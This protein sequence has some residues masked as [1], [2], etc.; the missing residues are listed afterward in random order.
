M[1]I[2]KKNLVVCCLAP[3]LVLGACAQ[4]PK[5]KNTIDLPDG[6]LKKIEMS[7]AEWKQKLNEFEFYV[8]RDKGT[9]RAFTGEFWDNKKSGTYTCGGCALPLF[10][11]TTKFKSGTGWPSFWE[12][13]NE[14]YVAE[15]TDRAFGMVR[16]EVLC[17]RCDGH[18][19]HVFPDGPKPTGLRYC[20]NSISLDFI[21]EAKT[22]E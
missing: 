21:P 3:L 1:V 22:T 5:D 16:T 19:G 4:I 12:P 13:I 7:E 8:L 9:E 6:E 15:E 17:A 18:L 14:E 11:S 10:S 20:I 2:S